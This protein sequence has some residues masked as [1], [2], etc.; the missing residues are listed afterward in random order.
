MHFEDAFGLVDFDLIQII[1]C[2]NWGKEKRANLS[3]GLRPSI[4]GPLYF[5]AQNPKG[6]ILRINSTNGHLIMP[7]FLFWLSN[8]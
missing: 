6:K 3:L 5:Q 7:T 2:F 4:K 8:F 1:Y